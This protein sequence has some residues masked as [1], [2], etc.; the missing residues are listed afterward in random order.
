M[1]TN[2]IYIKNPKLKKD[3]TPEQIDFNPFDKD[4]DRTGFYVP[5]G[6]CGECIQQKINQYTV[7][8]YYEYLDCKDHHGVSFFSTLTYD[9]KHVPT[10]MGLRTFSYDDRANFIRNLKLY[11]KRAGYPI[12]SIYVD[13]NGVKIKKSNFTYIWVCEYG[14]TYERPHYHIVFH[15]FFPIPAK[16][17]NSIVNRC[18]SKGFTQTSNPYDPK[19]FENYENTIVKDSLGAI[20]YVSKYVSKACSIIDAINE[21]PESKFLLKLNE[22]R[23]KCGDEP[24]DTVTDLSELRGYDY[25][26]DRCLPKTFYS[27]G[28]GAYA[29]VKCTPQQ[30]LSGKI[31]M[32]DKFVKS[33]VRF[34]SIPYLDRKLYY[35]ISSDGKN[36]RLN[37]K[38]LEMKDFRRVHNIDYVA[39]NIFETFYYAAVD[40]SNKDNYLS[41]INKISDKYIHKTFDSIESFMN[42]CH[43]MNDDVRLR[44]ASNKVLLDNFD[45]YAIDLCRYHMFNK[46][47]LDLVTKRLSTSV[48]DWFNHSLNHLYYSS[49]ILTLYNA[50][51]RQKGVAIHKKYIEDR[52]KE[53]EL[54]RA[55]SYYKY[56]NSHDPDLDN[57]FDY[58]NKLYLDSLIREDFQELMYDLHQT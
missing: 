47:S 8:T 25:N 24:L 48:D 33:K 38:G 54:K 50:I 21:Q 32:D 18:W 46:K 53:R 29:L 6:R 22:M 35:D 28:Y 2:P 40:S 27:N 26:L 58:K 9:E 31:P 10:Y 52:Q 19:W 56:F 1:C 42:D 11:L 45:I 36:V 7:R 44:I 34:A 51:R 57:Q 13:Y 16:L 20:Q 14:E 41:V 17:F 15:C 5:C 37:D 12:F 30:L 55:K 23:M 4:L 43:I 3:R 39:N 49:Y